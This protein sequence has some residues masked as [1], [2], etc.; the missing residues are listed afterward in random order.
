MSSIPSV[1]EFFADY[2]DEGHVFKEPGLKVQLRDGGIEAMICA[3]LPK[4]DEGR[5][6][7]IGADD[8]W[9]IDGNAYNNIGVPHSKDIIAILDGDKVIA[10]AL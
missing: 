3:V 5:Y 1:E 7:I 10:G 6:H 9:F 8:C 2:A 4:Y